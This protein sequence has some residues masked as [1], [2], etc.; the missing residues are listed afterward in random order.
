VG[1][2]PNCLRERSLFSKIISFQYLSSRFLVV[3]L[4]L[5]R[6][7]NV[8]SHPSY[9]SNIHFLSL[10]LTVIFL[11]R[12]IASMPTIYIDIVADVKYMQHNYRCGETK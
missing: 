6:L 9:Y 7:R 4:K 5:I 2:S 12:F 11:R 1:A 3:L 8:S 10:I